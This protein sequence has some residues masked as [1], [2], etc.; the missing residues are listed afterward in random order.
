[1]YKLIK[2]IKRGLVGDS[3]SKMWR[4]FGK[5]EITNFKKEY[6]DLIRFF[7]EVKENNNEMAQSISKKN[8]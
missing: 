4:E 3:P 7:E 1:M 8:D 6:E 5:R 2:L